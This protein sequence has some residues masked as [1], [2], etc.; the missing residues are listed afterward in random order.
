VLEN[1][2]VRAAWVA[3]VA[4]ARRVVPVALAVLENPAVWVA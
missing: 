4:L 2:A 3:S 1:P